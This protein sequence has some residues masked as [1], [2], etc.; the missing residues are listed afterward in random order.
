MEGLLL[1]DFQT[2]FDSPVWG[3]R[4]NPDAE[5]EAARL[6]AAWRGGRGPVF[7][8]RHCSVEAGSPLTPE[9]GG[10]AFKPELAPLP[11]EATYEKTVNSA[12]IGTALEADLR[13]RGVTDLVV[14]GLTTPHCVSTSCRMAAN[15]GFAVTLAHDACAAYAANADVS[16]APGRAPM[17]PEEIHAAAVSHLHAEFVTARRTAE[18]LGG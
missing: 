15:F 14:C 10:T 5:S 3:A 18:I 2:G 7:H 16:W 12:F 6:L 1:I 11:G 17:G 8:V 13:A 4:N 9:A